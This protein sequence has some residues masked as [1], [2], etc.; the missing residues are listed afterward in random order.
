[1]NLNCDEQYR[2]SK[3]YK[4]FSLKNEVEHVDL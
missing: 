2:Y 1:M 4:N 3:F